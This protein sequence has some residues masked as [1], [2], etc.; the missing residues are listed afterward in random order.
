MA[1]MPLAILMAAGIVAAL[2]GR[3]VVIVWA[4]ALAI[5]HLVWIVLS[6]EATSEDS[7]TTLIALSVI[8]IHLAFLGLVG[9]LLIGDA[10]RSR[11]QSIDTH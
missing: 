5:A 2:I 4:V 3:H 9:G 8:F 7:K 1:L 11:D 6:D 10:A